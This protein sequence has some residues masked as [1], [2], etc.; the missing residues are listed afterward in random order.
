[1]HDDPSKTTP[2]G[3]ARYA[4]DFFDSARAMENQLNNTTPFELVSPMPSLYLIG[5]SIELALK[6]YLLHHGQTLREL[7]SM[8]YGH[9][10]HACQKK[11]KELGLSGLVNFHPAEEAAVELLNNLYS[12]KQLE[13]IVTGTKYLPTFQLVESF[14]RRLIRAVAKDVGYTE[15]NR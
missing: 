14:A 4:H 9:D 5:H 10:L 6:A 11:A 1:M 12:T 13:Y 2:S 8:K 15:F 3:L 7:R